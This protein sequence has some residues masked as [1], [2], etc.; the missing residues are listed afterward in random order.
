MDECGE[1]YCNEE[2]P[3]DYISRMTSATSLR[4]KQEQLTHAITWVYFLVII[5]GRLFLGAVCAFIQPIYG[6]L[7]GLRVTLTERAHLI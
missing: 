4:D 5:I 2:N 3:D 6:N 7:R 1:S